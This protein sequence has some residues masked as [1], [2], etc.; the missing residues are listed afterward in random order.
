[1][2]RQQVSPRETRALVDVVIAGK[3]DSPNLSHKERDKGLLFV[4]PALKLNRQWLRQCK[5]VELDQACAQQGVPENITRHEI[6]RGCRLIDA[7]LLEHRRDAWQP[8]KD[9]VGFGNA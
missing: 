1:M 4:I 2:S 9:F 3:R 6:T 7:Q 5:L 8:P